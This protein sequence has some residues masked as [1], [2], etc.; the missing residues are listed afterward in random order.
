MYGPE[1]VCVCLCVS[2]TYSEYVCGGSS[3]SVKTKSL[4]ACVF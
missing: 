3:T 1:E 4:C 2:G